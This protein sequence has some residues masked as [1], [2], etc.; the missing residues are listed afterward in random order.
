MLAEDAWWR[1]RLTALSDQPASVVVL[2][3]ASLGLACAWLGLLHV[4]GLVDWRRHASFL[5]GRGGD[6]RGSRWACAALAAGAALAFVVSV[7][8]QTQGRKLDDWL[9]VRPACTT[10]LGLLL[11]SEVL[12]ALATG[13][14]LGAAVA[15]AAPRLS[16]GDRL[17]SLGLAAL[18]GGAACLALVGFT[19]RVG[20]RVDAAL[21]LADVAGLPAATAPPVEALLVVLAR[22]RAYACP[23]PDGVGGVPFD[24]AAARAVDAWLDHRRGLT[25]LAPRAEQHVVLER[26]WHLDPAG[27]RDRAERALRRRGGSWAAQVL[28]LTLAKAPPDARTRAVLTTAA[29]DESLSWGP[30]G[31]HGL[32]VGLARHGDA[33]AVRALVQ[34]VAAR[35]GTRFLQGWGGAQPLLLSTFTD[36]TVRGRLVVDGAPWRG[37]VGL[38]ATSDLFVLPPPGGVCPATW[39]LRVGATSACDA[40]GSFALHGLGP[41]EHAL[42]LLVGRASGVGREPTASCA[43]PL[44]ALRLSGPA[45]SLD[46]GTIELRLRT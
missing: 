9:A 31:L 13:L 37:N 10:T 32:A 44:P 7:V 14:V 42:V 27:A 15:S 18:L 40:E 5:L 17:R 6:P 39:L 3:L 8:A 43:S 28:L 2:L 11:C 45:Q 36:G 16:P 22:D 1:T 29:D 33:R 12:A 26:A 21:E 46:V 25:H 23:I 24:P 41:G 19:G 20:A 30:I 35:G 4:T 38:V 34:A